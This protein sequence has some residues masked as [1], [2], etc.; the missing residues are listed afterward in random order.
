MS[1]RQ[2]F[3]FSFG[4]RQRLELVDLVPQQVPA[5][6][7][8][9]RPLVQVMQPRPLRLPIAMA[10]PNGIRQIRRYAEVVEQLEL[11]GALEQRTMLVLR[12]HIHHGSAE[13]LQRGDIDR[14]TV[15][16]GARATGGRG[17]ATHEAAAR[18]RIVFQRMLGYVLERRAAPIKVE[19]GRHLGTRRAGT[20]AGSVGT[21]AKHQVKGM[22]QYGFA[23][24]G[25]AGDDRESRAKLDVEA[26]HQGEIPDRELLQHC[27]R[28][29]DEA[30]ATKS[31]ALLALCR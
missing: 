13:V 30:S 27:A 11:S 2:R 21:A 15:D 4:E 31:V 16:E 25:L 24:A 14:R 12:I 7:R 20:N 8:R 29:A 6:A 22:Q 26:F 23:G 3:H 10:D 18:F 1:L 28:V 17:G 5:L 19:L 9:P